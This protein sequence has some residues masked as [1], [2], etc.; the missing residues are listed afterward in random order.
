MR[1]VAKY[2]KENPAVSVTITGHTDDVGD[3]SANQSLSDKRAAAVAASL[4]ADF[5]VEAGRLATAGKGESVPIAKNDSPE[6][7]AMNRR[8]EFAKG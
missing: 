6:G 4:S 8:V 1:Q 7:R 2:M 3:D 5:G